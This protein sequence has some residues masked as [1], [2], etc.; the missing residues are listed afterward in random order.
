MSR[1]NKP[2]ITAE[3]IAVAVTSA[4]MLV[5]GVLYAVIRIVAEIII[6]VAKSPKIYKAVPKMLNVVPA[7]VADVTKGVSNNYKHLKHNCTYTA[8]N[9]LD[10]AREQV[11]A[12]QTEKVRAQTLDELK[13]LLIGTEGRLYYSIEKTEF[14]AEGRVREYINFL[15][16]DRQ[17]VAT[18]N[19]NSMVNTALNNVLG[20]YNGRSKKL[21]GTIVLEDYA[22]D[23]KDITKNLEDKLGIEVKMVIA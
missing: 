19:A 14:P 18:V 3:L 15:T 9:Y 17:T 12:I 4:V 1:K 8:Q 20:I 13:R 10:E 5:I 22:C 6:Q 2:I 16:Y 21:H 11:L 7:T 23:M